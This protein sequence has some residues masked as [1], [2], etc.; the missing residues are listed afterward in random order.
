MCMITGLLDHRDGFSYV[1]DRITVMAS[2]MNSP[3]L[4]HLAG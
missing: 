4:E 1:L 2:P 3:A